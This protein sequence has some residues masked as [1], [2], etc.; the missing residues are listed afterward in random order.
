MSSRK[1]TLTIVFMVLLAGCGGPPATDQEIA[2]EETV[3]LDCDGQVSE[4]T[5]E[6][7][8][9][10]SSNDAGSVYGEISYYDSDGERTQI[11]TF[12]VN[13]ESTHRMA[14]GYEDMDVASTT[15]LYVQ[16]KED[17]LIS[18]ETLGGDSTQEIAVESREE[19]QPVRDPTFNF[20]PEIPAPGEQ[21][22]F[23]IIET[24][25]EGCD[26]ETVDWDFTDDGAVNAQGTTAEYTFSEEGYHGVTT[27][28]TTESGFEFTL[29]D[30]ILV[31]DDEGM[32]FRDSADPMPQTVIVPQLLIQVLVTLG[33]SVIVIVYA[34][35]R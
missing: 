34:R 31:T 4:I 26:I 25:G 20:D 19:D 6:T 33:L 14:I 13:G 3:D 30:T 1:A 7:T 23:E 27:T 35:Q 8:V 32:E 18:D 5:V 10:V 24:A 12:D 15:M 9:S 16:L 21:V 22:T 29:T 17:N 2:V 28:V 11:E